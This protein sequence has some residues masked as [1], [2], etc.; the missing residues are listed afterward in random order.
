MQVPANFVV[1]T[2]PVRPGICKGGNVLIRILDH[3]VAVERQ[4]RSLAQAGHYRRPDGDIGHKMPVHD[5]D[6][7]HRAAAPLRRGNLVRQV[8]KIR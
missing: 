1:H 6:M 7:D 2:H 3:Q 5:V 8:R 4:L